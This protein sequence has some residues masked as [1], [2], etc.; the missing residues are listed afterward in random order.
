MRIAVT[1]DDGTTADITH[2]VRGAYQMLWEGTR[3]DRDWS[4]DDVETLAALAQAI[5]HEWADEAAKIAAT[6]RRED[7][8]ERAE[9]VRWQQDRAN[10]VVSALA[11]LD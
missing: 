8:E 1:H 9:R 5:R 3:F 7:D 6:V 2:L 4:A 10:V 11:G